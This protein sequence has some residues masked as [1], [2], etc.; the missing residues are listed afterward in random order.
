MYLRESRRQHMQKCRNRA[1]VFVRKAVGGEALEKREG[2]VEFG[3]RGALKAGQKVRRQ[4]GKKRHT[5]RAAALLELVG[6]FC[7]E[8]SLDSAA[9]TS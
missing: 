9:E 3:R 6:I 5:L 2:I 4:V 1:F 8:K 7:Q